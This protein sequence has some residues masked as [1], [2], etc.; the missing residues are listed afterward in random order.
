ME[1]PGFEPGSKQGTKLLST[2]L[3]CGWLSDIRWS[4]ATYAYLSSLFSKRNRSFFRFYPCFTTLRY[5]TPQGKGFCGVLVLCLLE[6]KN[7]P[8]IIKRRVHNQRCQLLAREPVLR[9]YSH[10]SACLQFHSL[11]VKTKSAP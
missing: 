7:N 10:G 5:Q 1:L 3:A 2:C 8:L 9:A 4:Q 11:A 6:T